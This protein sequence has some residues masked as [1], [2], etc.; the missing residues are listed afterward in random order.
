MQ[1][2]SSSFFTC[3]TEGSS[4][5]AP[6]KVIRWDGRVNCG[7]SCLLTLSMPRRW[8]CFPPFLLSPHPLC[9]GIE[10]G[11]E[12][13]LAGSSVSCTLLFGAMVFAYV[14]RN[15]LCMYKYTALVMGDIEL[16]CD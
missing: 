2:F 4:H 12:N 14:L 11:T 5:G 10:P 3:P 6:L 8:S 13:E 9:G 16:I 15:S 1:F 7:E